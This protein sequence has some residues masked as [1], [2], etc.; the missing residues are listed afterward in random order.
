MVCG[1]GLPVSIGTEVSQ[2]ADAISTARGR[3][4]ECP[5]AAH[6]RDATLASIANMGEPCDRNSV[7]SGLTTAARRALRG[8][9]SLLEQAF[10]RQRLLDLGPRPDAGFVRR[11]YRPLGEIDPDEA[12]PAQ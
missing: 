11:E 9:R 6:A 5:S 4:N 7:G 12:G 10:S 2:C 3:G 1:L 8:L